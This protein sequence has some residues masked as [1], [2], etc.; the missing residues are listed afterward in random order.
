MRKLVFAIGVVFC[1]QLSFQVY[2]A[3][4]QSDAEYAL[5]RST[6]TPAKPPGEAILAALEPAVLNTGISTAN[7]RSILVSSRIPAPRSVL[8]SEARYSRSHAD[9]MTSSVAAWRPIV[10]TY[11]K[12]ASS[13]AVTFCGGRKV[14]APQPEERKS[15]LAKALPVI[16]KPYDWLKA[17]GSKLR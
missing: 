1:V 15:L 5:M 8:V 14:S 17:V 7:S 6:T 9:P 3:F 12:P 11:K 2:M 10:I 13:E 16:K 4:E